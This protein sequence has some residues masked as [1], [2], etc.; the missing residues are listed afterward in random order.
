MKHTLRSLLVFALLVAV[1]ASSALAQ[2]NID[3]AISEAESNLGK[4]QTYFTSGTGFAWLVV[5]LS[6][7]IFW[8]RRL[9][10]GKV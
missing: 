4:I 1:S 8:A 6:A 10:K 7:I 2:T 9:F 5:G 3:G